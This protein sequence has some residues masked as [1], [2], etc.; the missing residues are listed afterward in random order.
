MNNDIYMLAFTAQL[1]PDEIDPGSG[2]IEKMTLLEHER[3]ELFICAIKMAAIQLCSAVMILLYLMYAE[4]GK[5]VT[6]TTPKSFFVILPR[7]ISGFMMH[8]NVMEDV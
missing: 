2:Y 8:L 6:F 3:S 4:N 5:G 1:N 7:L